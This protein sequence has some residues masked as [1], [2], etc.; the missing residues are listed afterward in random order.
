[1]GFGVPVKEW[2][3][4]DLKDYG[5]DMVL[6]GA[7]NRQFIEAPM[8]EKFW[9]EHQSGLHKRS[10]ELWLSRFKKQERIVCPAICD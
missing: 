4:K 2:L 6:N 9:N 10:T 3:R 5:G 1:M 8:L 7:A